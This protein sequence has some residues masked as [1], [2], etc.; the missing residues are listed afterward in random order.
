MPPK[1]RFQPTSLP[2]LRSVRAAAE[3]EHE[4]PE[5]RMS[6]TPARDT[7][8]P[9]PGAVPKLS[10]AVSRGRDFLGRANLPPGF[11]KMWLGQVRVQLRKIYG[12]D[13]EAEQHWPVV[14]DAITR[15]QARELLRVRLSRAERLLATL[16]DAATKLS[17]GL[18]DTAYSLVTVAHPYGASLRTSCKTG[19]AYRGRSSIGNRFLVSQRPGVSNTC[20]ESRRSPSS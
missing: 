18:R 5:H 1:D 11:V 4:G 3:P 14:Q 17:R 13:S 10:D 8:P 7:T 19:S 12:P 2:P 6:T 20:S 9:E 16:S 15:D